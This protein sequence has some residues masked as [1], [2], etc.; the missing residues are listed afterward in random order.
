MKIVMTA[1]IAIVLSLAVAGPAVA[2]EMSMCPHEETIQSLRDCV[3]HAK[4]Q[5]HIDSQGVTQSL[6]AKLD[7]AA[8]AQE[9]DQPAVAIN[10]LEAFV[11]ELDAQAGQHIVTPHAGHLEMHAQMV[12]DALDA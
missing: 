8:R 7:A 11:S 3:L 6:L 10:I 1:A 4:E 12:I 2:Q 5:A 9:R